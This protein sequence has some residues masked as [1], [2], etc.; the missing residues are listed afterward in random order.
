MDIVQHGYSY[1]GNPNVQQ[2]IAFFPLY[3]II[4]K[5]LGQLFG[6]QNGVATI[7]P[8]LFFGVA[9]IYAFHALART[10]LHENASLFA[11]AAYALYPGA[12][13]FVSAYPTSIMN[14]LVIITFLAFNKKRYF[15]AAIAAG[16]STA[17]GALLV[18]F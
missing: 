5:V 14:L 2:N 13:F 9:S 3:P 12:T 6:L 11:T 8:A 1:N 15:I 4:M 18:F 7:F 17:G 10:R 16:V